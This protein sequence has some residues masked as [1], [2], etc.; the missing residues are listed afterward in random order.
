MLKLLSRTMLASALIAAVARFGAR[1]KSR[2]VPHAPSGPPR[3]VVVLDPDQI[4]AAVTVALDAALPGM[5]EE[6]SAR[7]LAALAGSGR[8]AP[9]S[10]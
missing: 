3:A 8:K 7:V 6:V 4:R 1:S 9:A 10:E 2:A 5:I